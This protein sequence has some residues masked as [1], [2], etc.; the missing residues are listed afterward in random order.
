MKTEVFKNCS[1]SEDFHKIDAFSGENDLVSGRSLSV[2]TKPVSV[3]IFRQ[4]TAGSNQTLTKKPAQV[5]TATLCFTEKKD[6]LL[7]KI[8][9]SLKMDF[10]SGK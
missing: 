6:F 2:C 7:Y 10:M 1:Q 8:Y 5:S 9:L 3:F 4:P